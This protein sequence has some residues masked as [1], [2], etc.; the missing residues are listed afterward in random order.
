MVLCCSVQSQQGA[1]QLRLAQAETAPVWQQEV[2]KRVGVRRAAF[3]LVYINA[4][5]FQIKINLH[6]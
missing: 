5:Y 1:G 6:C 3:S 2:Q 4:H